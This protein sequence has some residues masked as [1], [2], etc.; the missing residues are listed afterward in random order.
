MLSC[1]RKPMPIIMNSTYNMKCLWLLIATQLSTQGQWLQQV[2]WVQTFHGRNMILLVFSRHTSTAPSAMFAAQWFSYHT[3]CAKMCFVEC[4]VLDELIN[5]VFCLATSRAFGY[6]S[7]ICRHCHE[8]E[9]C[10]ETVTGC[11][12]H[13]KEEMRRKSI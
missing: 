10:A 5:R 12:H 8:V 4:I 7:G 1:I 13:V 11:K 2:S 6:I 3:C 9:V